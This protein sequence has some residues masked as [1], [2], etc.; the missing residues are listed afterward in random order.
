[1]KPFR[2]GV[3]ILARWQGGDSPACGCWDPDIQELLSR[4][5]QTGRP[6]DR[7]P[8]SRL[9]RAFPVT[10]SISQTDREE[11]ENVFFSFDAQKKPT[12]NQFWC[13]QRELSAGPREILSH[14][15]DTMGPPV[16][17]MEGNPTELQ[18]TTRCSPNSLLGG[19]PGFISLK[20]WSSSRSPFPIWVRCSQLSCSHIS[21][22]KTGGFML[23]L[24]GQLIVPVHLPSLYSHAPPYHFHLWGETNKSSSDS[25][26]ILPGEPSAQSAPGA[27]LGVCPS[28]QLCRPCQWRCH[29]HWPVPPLAESS[30][31]PITLNTLLRRVFSSA[32]LVRPLCNC[33]LFHALACSYSKS[34]SKIALPT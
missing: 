11:L 23:H 1:M 29:H 24:P 6:T 20:P 16:T 15:E 19:A 33:E 9:T 7:Q 25:I 31:F 4:D 34:S 18:P 2:P 22:P 32:L 5:T 12:T 10:Y 30:L 21:F 13:M 3:V 27:G 28:H 17:G 14:W 26:Q 8:S